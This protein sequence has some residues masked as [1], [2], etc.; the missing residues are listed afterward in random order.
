MQSGCTVCQKQMIAGTIRFKCRACPLG[1]SAWAPMPVMAFAS[2]HRGYANAGQMDCRNGQAC[3]SENYT[4]YS[5]FIPL[6]NARCFWKTRFSHKGQFLIPSYLKSILQL[7]CILKHSFLANASRMYKAF[8]QKYRTFFVQIRMFCKAQWQTSSIPMRS[9][10][11]RCCHTEP[12]VIS[13]LTSL[14][15]AS[16]QSRQQAGKKGTSWKRSLKN[17]NQNQN[18]ESLKH[19]LAATME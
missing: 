3:S 12:S 9:S 1:R 19:Y 14:L 11:K 4:D 5:L 7:F 15:A 16:M 6:T 13:R 8:R 17:Q 18:M 10:A 2:R